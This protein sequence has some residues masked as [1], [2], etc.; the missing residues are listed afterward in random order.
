MCEKEIS[1]FNAMN[2]YLASIILDVF[3]IL[4]PSFFCKIEVLFSNIEYFVYHKEG[5][6]KI[7]LIS[8]NPAF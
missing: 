8:Y 6:Y 5:S 1:G 3:D 7:S 4:S 2:Q